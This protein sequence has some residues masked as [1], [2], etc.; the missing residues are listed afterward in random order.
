[1]TRKPKTTMLDAALHYATLGYRVF[2]CRPNAK[3]PATNHGL[4]DAT[5]DLDTITGWWT[6]QPD[7]NIGLLTTGLVVVDFD[8]PQTAWPGADRARDFA[9]SPIQR[10]PR[11]G[12][13]VVLSAGESRY[14]NT[15]SKIAESVDTRADGGYIVVAP[16][17]VDGK[18]YAWV[19]PLEPRED[20]PV[21]PAWLAADLE[22][23]S[24][25][26]AEEAAQKPRE[27][28]WAA[29][30][31]NAAL[32]SMAGW[33]RR[34]GLSEREIEAVLQVANRDRCRPP[35]DASEVTRIAKSIAR[36]AAGQMP[37][38]PARS[39]QS[40]QSDID[41]QPITAA[42]LAKQNIQIN[43]LVNYMLADGQSCIL[44]GP[45]KTLKTSIALDLC[46]SLATAGLFLGRFQVP[47]ARRV[48]FMSGE[49][50]AATM[51]ETLLRIC[52]AAAVDPA[53]L[54]NLLITERLPQIGHEEH[55]EAMEAFI[56]DHEVEV[57]VIDPAYMAM[58]AMGGDANNLFLVGGN[59][60]RLN[61]LTAQTG[62]SFVL[63]HH[64]RK[65]LGEDKFAMPELDGIA[66]AGFQEWTRQWVLLNRRETYEPGTGF[67]QLWMSVGGSAG[68]GGAW[69]L[70]IYEGTRAEGQVRTWDVEI[71]DTAEVMEDRERRK[72]ATAEQRK[73]KQLEADLRDVCYK[74]AEYPNGLTKSKLREMVK[75]SGARCT[76]AVDEGIDRGNLIHCTV[77]LD[78]QNKTYPGV[79]LNDSDSQFSNNGGK[80]DSTGLNRTN[81]ES[82]GRGGESDSTHINMGPSPTPPQSD[83]PD[84]RR[85]QS[86]RRRGAVPTHSEFNQFNGD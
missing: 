13:H 50:G 12:K 46:I 45:K 8:D 36:Y 3:V 76:A 10:T 69:G 51:Q 84:S 68:H 4:K 22:R 64:T 85:T 39:D 16:S 30:Q 5:D 21:V 26:R 61:D 81:A 32:S 83:Q 31:R 57:C 52:D 75:R 34:D 86:G 44:A 58:A 9:G 47:Q 35:L 2:P 73:T 25:P 71:K 27:G 60:R 79:R 54:T 80:P 29:G 67:H 17:M 42:E 24:N 33:L 56:A 18:Q 63:L 82:P 6:K 15:A 74:L 41:Y 40:G 48:A 59:L 62:C 7:A 78:G 65:H 72:E 14:R 70:D 43:W 55:Q 1:M 37:D 23:F 53:G 28:R 49:S 11:G 77:R 19:V 66:W 20:L 38:S